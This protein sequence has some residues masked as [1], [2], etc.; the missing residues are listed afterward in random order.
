MKQKKQKK[1]Y[2]KK[3]TKSRL[4]L[5]PQYERKSKE[6]I[7]YLA[8]SRKKLNKTKKTIK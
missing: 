7:K 6:K 3:F 1:V 2:A 4:K 5:T 8:K